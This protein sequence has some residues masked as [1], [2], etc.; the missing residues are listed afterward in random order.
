MIKGS[1][2]QQD[3]K[4]EMYM[5]PCIL[6]HLYM[7]KHLYILSQYNVNRETENNITIVRDFN[8]PL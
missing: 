1:I 8:I 4:L 6:K 5:H 3:V 2:I 7:L